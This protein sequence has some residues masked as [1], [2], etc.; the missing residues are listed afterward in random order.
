MGNHP[1]TGVPG[2]AG[3]REIA[4]AESGRTGEPLEAFRKE[5]ERDDHLKNLGFKR[6]KS[7][8][9]SISKRLKRHKK[10]ED[11][12]DVGPNDANRSDPEPSAA[13]ELSSAA[14]KP[15]RSS[16][17]ERVERIDPPRRRPLVGEPQPLPT[18]VQV[19]SP[20]VQQQTAFSKKSAN[21]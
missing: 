16:S 20:T 4:K 3:A 18:H 11:V 8:R 10:H 13:V 17:N 19:G 21:C 7:L 15:K 5:K 2:A 1:S 14:S 12:V 6:S 9:K